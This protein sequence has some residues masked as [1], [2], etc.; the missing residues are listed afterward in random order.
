M[1]RSLLH[2]LRAA[3]VAAIATTAGLGAFAQVGTGFD[4]SGSKSLIAVIADGTKATIGAIQFTPAEGGGATF[5]ITLKTEVFTDFFLSM[6]EFKCLPAAKEI[7]CHVPYPYA[8]P[9]TV[10]PGN[11]AWLEHSL[12]FLHKSPAEFG[13]KLWNG[14]YYEFQVQGNAL[15]GT[16][17]AVDLNEI[18]AP[19]RDASV[20]PFGKALRHEVPPGARWLAALLIE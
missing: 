12:L 2:H 19:P 20:P 18:A 17:R 13:A 16:P 7:S 10:G 11:L 6:R 5:K 14:L 4:F 1:P 3:L 8:N 15:A 9:A